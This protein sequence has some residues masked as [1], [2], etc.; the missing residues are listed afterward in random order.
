MASWL[1]AQRNTSKLVVGLVVSPLWL[2]LLVLV[3]HMVLIAGGSASSQVRF[4]TDSEFDL[5][6]TLLF[7]VLLG[8]FNFSLATLLL[9]RL[10]HKL[11]T[12]SDTDQLTGLYNRRVMMRRLDNEHARYQRSGKVV[13]CFAGDGAYSNGVVLESLNWAAQYQ[14]TNE[15]AK[16][17]KAG[18]P[19]IFLIVNNQEIAVKN[20]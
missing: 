13:C 1:Y 17:D 15:L 16:E 5:S 10:I 3:L 4:N 11:R 8:G 7:L 18:L 14:F 20:I 19:I 2:A 12:L 6:V 9:G